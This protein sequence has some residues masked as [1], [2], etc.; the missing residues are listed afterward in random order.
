MRFRINPSG[1]DYQVLPD[2]SR[3]ETIPTGLLQVFVDFALSLAKQYQQVQSGLKT[4]KKDSK[5]ADA[6]ID[7]FL[8][9]QNVVGFSEQ[10]ITA[11]SLQSIPQK[12]LITAFLS[13]KLL[14]VKMLPEG[15]DLRDYH[16]PPPQV[17]LKEGYTLHYHIHDEQQGATFF[18]A[19]NPEGIP[20]GKLIVIMKF[21]EESENFERVEGFDIHIREDGSSCSICV[22]GNLLVPATEKLQKIQRLRCK[23][24]SDRIKK[25]VNILLLRCG[26]LKVFLHHARLQ[27]R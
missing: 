15:F 27:M 24:V 21:T 9:L 8:S 26:S 5:K 19:S 20:F 12:E 11:S 3:W 18:F 25:A 6:F 1:G 16:A 7:S 14:Q 22:T 17:I 13:K 4:T 2:I 23:T 10:P